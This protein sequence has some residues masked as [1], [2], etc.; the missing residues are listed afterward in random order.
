MLLVALTAGVFALHLFHATRVGGPTVSFD[1]TGYLGN[2]RWFAGSEFRWEM[3]TS[4]TYAI[5]YPLVLAPFF[6]VV[7]SPARQWWVVALV[8]ATLLASMVPLGYLVA[9]RALHA[10][11]TAALAAA[12]VAALLPAAIAASPVAIAENLVLPL[13]MVCVLALSR[14]LRPGSPWG[15]IWFGPAIGVLYGTHPRFVGVVAVAVVVLVVAM[16]RRRTPAVIGLTNLA[17]LA[18]GVVEVRILQSR[19][20]D[21]RWAHVESFG[22]ARDVL[23]LLRTRDGIFEIALLA[24]G[25][26][27]YLLVGS[28]GLG[29]VGVYGWFRRARGGD[30][31]GTGRGG[32]GR[33]GTA[34]VT[35]D[36]LLVGFVLASAGVV[37]AASVAFFSLVQFRV[38]HLVY[39]RHNDSF[40]PIWVLAAVV[41][42][43]DGPARSVRRRWFTAAGLIVVS[44]VVLLITR[45]PES[46]G[47]MHAAFAVPATALFHDSGSP[48]VW[49]L[50]AVVAVAVALAVGATAVGATAVRFGARRLALVAMV[51]CFVAAGHQVVRSTQE[52]EVLSYSGLEAPEL[53]GRVGVSSLAIDSAAVEVAVPV[54]TYGWLLPE[55][56]VTTFD[57]RRGDGPRGDV[58]LARVDDP[59]FSGPDAEARVLLYDASAFVE[60]RGAPAGLAVFVLPGAEQDRLADQGWLLPS[61][62]PTELPSSARRV[63]LALP[64]GVEEIDVPSGGVT[65]VRLTVSHEGAGAPWPDGR[66][67]VGPVREARVRV[68]MRSDGATDPT[69][70]GGPI[71]GAELPGWML[72]GDR[73]TTELGVLG[74]DAEGRP[75][76]PGRYRIRLGVTQDGVTQ[77][78]QRWFD[79]RS[80]PVELTIRVTG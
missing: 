16:V 79:E 20:W 42:L 65:T 72:P 80:D 18:V 49:V 59:A 48:W 57:R 30:P 3:P 45:D 33:G 67:L 43:W 1:E 32:T 70:P 76:E 11:P 53:L 13:L 22:G 35:A 12:G 77:N 78:E 61:G 71:V 4:P 63:S 8:N 15:R 14:V 34:R 55:V 17:L 66:Q 73:V 23:D 31:G 62:F 46:F 7:G 40:T 37:F 21:E 19:V 25:Q 54:L 24:W 47:G 69:D 74:S 41:L 28:L 56:D 75:L 39:G 68:Q 64:D 2:A 50:P 26:A 51:G 9:R 27:W 36:P 38:D 52:V 29:V 10:A 58:V 5:G 44:T 60:R 6:A